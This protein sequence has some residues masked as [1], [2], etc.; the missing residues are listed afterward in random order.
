MERRWISTGGLPAAYLEALKNQ[1]SLTA[2]EEKDLAVRMRQGDNSAR[3]Q[4]IRCNLRFVLWEARRY[5]GRGF[6][7]VDL[8]Q[9]GHVGLLKALNHY[10][11]GRGHRFQTYALWCVRQAIQRAIIEKSTAIHLPAYVWPMFGRY[12]QAADRLRVETEREP[13]DREVAQ[14][15]GAEDV[16]I[17]T[18]L[19]NTGRV[20]ASLDSHDEEDKGNVLATT[21]FDPEEAIRFYVVEELLTLLDEKE[22]EVLVKR[23][24]L[25]GEVPLTLEE[26]GDCLGV[27]RE[28]IRQI[29]KKALDKLR[30][31]SREVSGL[32]YG[33]DQQKS[34]EKQ[35]H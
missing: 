5:L 7:L 1:P 3:E 20:T 10:D 11:P 6:P 21:D 18:R 16:G 8:V 24:G 27:S 12:F 19:Q 35:T 26:V 31:R 4:L 34:D 17:V 13:S 15:I 33:Q 30:T 23:F 22:R 14:E 32:R 9:E 25:R 29:E 2:E 28:R